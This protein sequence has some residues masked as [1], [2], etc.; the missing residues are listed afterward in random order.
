MYTCAGPSCVV[1]PGT[2]QVAS[3]TG[4]RAPVPQPA[5]HE[6]LRGR[7]CRRHAVG[8]VEC[9]R[10]RG[11]S[12]VELPGQACSSCPDRADPN[13]PGNAS[14]DLPARPAVD[15]Q[16][17]MARAT[18]RPGIGC[19]TTG[20]TTVKSPPRRTR[21]AAS[22]EPG[23]AIAAADVRQGPKSG[24]TRS[25]PWSREIRRQPGKKAR[26][27]NKTITHDSPPCQKNSVHAGEM[28][29]FS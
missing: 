19:V 11:W 27:V 16:G 17:V 2:T 6:S 20:L 13:A 25:R 9:R 1:N 15:P 23:E 5:E 26:L 28:V 22:S 24:V 21:R 3:R 12:R 10:S 7:A 29:A 18:G 8:Q 4:K 14:P